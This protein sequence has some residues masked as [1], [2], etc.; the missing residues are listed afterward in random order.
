MAVLPE[1]LHFFNNSQLHYVSVCLLSALEFQ[2]LLADSHTFGFKFFPNRWSISKKSSRSNCT[3][4]VVYERLKDDGRLFIWSFPACAD[5]LLDCSSEF[6]SC[7]SILNYYL[8]PT[9]SNHPNFSL[10][11]RTIFFP[12]CIKLTAML[13]A[14]ACRFSTAKLPFGKLI[15]QVAYRLF[16]ARCRQAKQCWIE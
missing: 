10:L 3:N 7:N 12:Q 2:K 13:P 11:T 6:Q 1:Y 15:I 4:S 14:T 8:Q 16:F 5:E 9:H